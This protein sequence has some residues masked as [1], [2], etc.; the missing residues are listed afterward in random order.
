[1]I[2]RDGL[3]GGT[4]IFSLNGRTVEE[5]KKDIYQNSS[6]KANIESYKKTTLRCLFHPLGFLLLGFSEAYS[7]VAKGKKE[8]IEL[9]NVNETI[10]N[11]GLCRI[12]HVR[13]TCV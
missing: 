7:I 1:L 4:V 6:S 8:P 11:L 3:T 9:L 5:I 2:N 12:T 10:S 13:K